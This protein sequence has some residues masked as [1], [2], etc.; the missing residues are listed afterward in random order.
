[1]ALF[2]NLALCFY[3][4]FVKTSHL[5]WAVLAMLCYLIA[6][7]TREEILPYAALIP[8]IGY[9]L[10]GERKPALQ[11][12]GILLV[13][14]LAFVILRRVFVTDAVSSLFLPGWL[15]QMSFALAPLLF[16]WSPLIG[17]VV[18]WLLILL[19]RPPCT[20]WFWLLCV[21]IAAAPGIIVWRGNN[22]LLPITFMALFLVAVFSQRRALHIVALTLYL[23]GS[24]VAH[25]HA[26]LGLAPN[27][28]VRVEQ[29]QRFIYGDWQN[30]LIW[31][32]IDRVEHLQSEAQIRD[33]IETSEFWSGW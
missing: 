23:V 3:L 10:S 4:R 17:F 28:S 25:R 6:L 24:V 18:L 1:M 5:K 9:C 19:V 30:T 29:A 21:G 7:L 8:L 31:I 20:V 13:V 2:G 12:G 22:S 16:D 27:S 11:I 26:Q 32:P 15:P 33:V 14:S